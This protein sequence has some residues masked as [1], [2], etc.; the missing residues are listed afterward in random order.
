[1]CNK[2]FCEM[3][4]VISQVATIKLL[5]MRISSIKIAK[6]SYFFIESHLPP[7]TQNCESAGEKTRGSA[8]F[9]PVVLMAA[10]EMFTLS[11]ESLDKSKMSSS[12]ACK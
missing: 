4:S 12:P 7:S 1:M 11:H 3:L 2:A 5:Q 9:S 8:R 6:F 10:N